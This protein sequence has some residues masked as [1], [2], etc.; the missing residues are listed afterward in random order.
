[1]NKFAKNGSIKDLVV[2]S[3]VRYSNKYYINKIV[4]NLDRTIKITGYT[5]E[6]ESDKSYIL[7]FGNFNYNYDVILISIGYMNTDKLNVLNLN[8]K[9]NNVLTN[10]LYDSVVVDNDRKFTLQ[11]NVPSWSNFGVISG[12]KMHIEVIKN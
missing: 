1:M 9:H 6:N 12:Y 11:F 10:V 8:P 7:L 3:D 2:A 5:S 4:T